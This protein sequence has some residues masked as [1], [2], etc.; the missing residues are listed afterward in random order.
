MTIRI[1]KPILLIIALI[2]SSVAFAQQDD[3]VLANQ[4]YSK[5]SFGK[6][7]PLYEKVLSKKYNHETAARLADC[8]RRNNQYKE[9][10]KWY[11]RVTADS[12][13][14]SQE[15]LLYSGVLTSLGK[16]DKAAAQMKKYL[17]KKP[18]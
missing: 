6:A 11:E 7:I 8:Y 2:A 3:L 1:M 10:E 9:A 14:T 18:A 4:L 13:A 16:K 17:D 5:Y 12:I 15:H